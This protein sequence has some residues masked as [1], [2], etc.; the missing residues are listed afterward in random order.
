M[1]L[2][3]MGLILP[4][5]QWLPVVGSGWSHT[6]VSLVITSMRNLVGIILLTGA[7]LEYTYRYV[8]ATKLQPTSFGDMVQVSQIPNIYE[9][10]NQITLS[11][12]SHFLLNQA[13]NVNNVVKGVVWV[14]SQTNWT[15]LI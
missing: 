2:V 15:R 13:C 6:T 9:F 3:G 4:P 1:S 11:L 12:K 10:I 8:P 7:K 14:A 5:M